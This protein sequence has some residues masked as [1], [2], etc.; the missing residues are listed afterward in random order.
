MPHLIKLVKFFIQKL[1]YINNIL[2][3]I[4]AP[5]LQK[6]YHVD[7]DG[8]IMNRCTSGLLTDISHNFT[9]PQCKDKWVY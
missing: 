3:N 5:I 7:T 2:Q 8:S 9:C 1:F 4:H 6:N